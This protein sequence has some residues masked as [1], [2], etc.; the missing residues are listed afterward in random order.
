MARQKKHQGETPEQDRAVREERLAA[1]EKA[2]TTG[3]VQ[4]ALRLKADE[5][6]TALVA[7]RAARD[8]AR[9]HAVNEAK[10]LC[11]SDAGRQ[12]ALSPGVWLALAAVVEEAC[13]Q[14]AR[15]TWLEVQ[16]TCIG[17]SIRPPF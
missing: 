12:G 4:E 3:E 11:E 15:V 13:K 16:A 6:N 7:A 5:I 14:Q 8:K 9:A 2:V 10:R 1:I 17:A